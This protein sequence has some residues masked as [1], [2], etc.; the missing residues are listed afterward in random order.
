LTDFSTKSGTRTRRRI[1]DT[2]KVGPLATESSAL[3]PRKIGQVEQN[4]ALTRKVRA[5]IENWQ[6]EALVSAKRE[7]ERNEVLV[8]EKRK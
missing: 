8:S 5:E 7:T 6:R 3:D 2:T 1:G 4:Q